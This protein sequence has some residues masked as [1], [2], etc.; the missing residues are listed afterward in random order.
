M[1]A[2][3]ATP[4]IPGSAGTPGSTGVP[5]GLE[6]TAQARVRDRVRE[7]VRRAEPPERSAL[8]GLV[9]ADAA[10]LGERGLADATDG[11]AADLLGLGPLRDLV[12]VPG[13]TDVLVNGDGSVW[14]DAGSG[15]VPG[16]VGLAGPEAVRRLAVRLAGLAGR[17]LDDSQPW[18]DGELP[19]GTRLHAVLA[20][21]AGVGAHVSLRIPRRDGWTLGALVG[22]GM[23]DAELAETLQGVVAARLTVVVSGGTGS[24]KTSLL[25]ALLAECPPH[26]RL[27]LVEDVRELH[28]RHPHVV[29]LQGR[30]A[31]VE[32]RGGVTLVDLVRQALRMRPD[33][34]VVGEVRG[35]E[36]RELLSALNT[37]HRGGFGTVH[38]NAPEQV[39]S[40]FVGLGALAGM[41]PDAV[42]RQLAGA[43]D[44]VVHVGR[45]TGGVRRVESVAVVEDGR[46][47]PALVLRA[48]SRGGT[49]RY[50]AAAGAE[51]L[52]HRVGRGPG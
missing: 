28:V 15:V 18:V 4:G 37:G 25:G 17:R 47:V 31:N 32:G 42:D 5:G 27:V 6:A 1:T 44:A 20:P 45:D 52:A 41:S 50:A 26:E 49:P 39:P 3:P 14:V 12:R 22:S 19:D 10:V 38:A 46:V 2:F 21:L 9:A 36:V 13:V 34:L 8:A 11:L 43:L 23:L 16:P 40:R 30:S 33:R 7:R 48:S 35:A 24:G 51:R 29:A